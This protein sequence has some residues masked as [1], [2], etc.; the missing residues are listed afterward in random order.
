VSLNVANC[1]RCGRVFVKGIQEICPNCLKEIELQFDK[2]SK[3]L[4][5]NRG[6]ILKDLSE[7]T[8]V[9]IRQIIKF[10]REGRIS[11]KN[12]PNMGYPCESCGND[13]RE[14]QICDPCRSKLAKD[15]TNTQEDEARRLERLRQDSKLSYNI[16]DRLKDRR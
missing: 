8:E 15:M 12:L 10:I 9:P 11:I 14:G 2:C 4:R 5:E 13:I 6:S 16:Q 7:A 1:P 3:Y